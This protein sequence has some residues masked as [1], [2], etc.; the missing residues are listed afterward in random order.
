[1]H[2]EGS[3]LSLPWLLLRTGPQANCILDVPTWTS[4]SLPKLKLC[5]PN[6]RPHP[7]PPC[8]QPSCLGLS[9]TLPCHLTP[10]SHS[11]PGTVR[12]PFK[13]KSDDLSPLSS[14]LPV[15]SHFSRSKSQTLSPKPW[16]YSAVTSMRSSL[17]TLYLKLQPSPSKKKTHTG[18]FLFPV[19][20]SPQ[21]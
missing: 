1:M 4:N 10:N 20:L 8:L 19:Y 2:A 15:N 6:H 7:R 3:Q 11:Q 17:I 14:K 13:Q 16:K 9:T 5:K 18:T 21:C 12:H